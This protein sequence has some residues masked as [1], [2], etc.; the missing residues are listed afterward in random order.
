MLSQIFVIYCTYIDFFVFNCC[1]LSVVCINCC[2]LSVV[3][4]NYSCCLYQL[5]LV[6]RKSFISFF[7]LLD[8]GPAMLTCDNL[9]F[10][11]CIS[12]TASRRNFFVRI[13]ALS[14]RALFV[15][16]CRHGRS[17]V[18]CVESELVV[19]CIILHLIIFLFIG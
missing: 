2:C 13:A 7:W 6:V 8:F 14:Q 11:L 3:C 9:L 4:I 18:S 12:E 16:S 10:F 5:S 17:A 15:L 1:C 19:N